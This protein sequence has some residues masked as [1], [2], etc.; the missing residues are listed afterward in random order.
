GS[1]TLQVGSIDVLVRWRK[2]CAGAG[3]FHDDRYQLRPEPLRAAFRADVLEVDGGTARYAGRASSA[4]CA[5]VRGCRCAGPVMPDREGNTATGERCVVVHDLRNDVRFLALLLAEPPRTDERHLDTACRVGA[6]DRPRPDPGDDV[7]VRRGA[8]HRVGD[9]RLRI[10]VADALLR[11]VAHPRAVAADV[12]LESGGAPPR[13]H[14][15]VRR[16]GEDGA[17]PGELRRDLDE[18]L[19]Y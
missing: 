17:L 7:C 2:I 11:T 14:A 9:R 5:V 13:A 8:G 6:R 12:L 16:A 4:H 19:V 18:G 15:L 3:P 10:Q 1:R